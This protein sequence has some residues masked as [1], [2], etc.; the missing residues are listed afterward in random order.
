[1][2][3]KMWCVGPIWFF[4]KVAVAYVR[5]QCCKEK[6]RKMQD[7]ENNQPLKTPYMLPSYVHNWESV[8]DWQARR[9]SWIVGS[10][11]GSNVNDRARR[12]TRTDF[13]TEH[14]D[15]KHFKHNISNQLHSKYSASIVSTASLKRYKAKAYL[16]W[17]DQRQQ[18]EAKGVSE[19]HLIQW[20]TCSIAVPDSLM[21]VLTEPP[22]SPSYEVK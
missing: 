9:I 14:F 16:E 11:L 19:K 3:S 20:Y 15:R 13:V 4:N 6:S 22:S 1:M 5:F 18:S 17:E 7:S 10:A 8:W 2:S 12:V 21:V